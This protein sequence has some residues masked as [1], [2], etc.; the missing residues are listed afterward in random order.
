MA[1]GKRRREG[2]DG[3][4]LGE[5]SDSP[6]F[7]TRPLRRLQRRGHR[8]GRVFQGSVGLGGGRRRAF[9]NEGNFQGLHPE[10]GADLGEAEALRRPLSG[11][12]G[13]YFHESWF[14]VQPEKIR[15]AVYRRRK[16]FKKIARAA[17]R[18]SRPRG[19]L[20]FGKSPDLP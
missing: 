4:S 13:E 12:L 19:S 8:A 1:D 17:S 20:C 18:D 10:M 15:K 14:L 7:G 11:F 16:T 3:D 6:R 9:F 5:E 2:R